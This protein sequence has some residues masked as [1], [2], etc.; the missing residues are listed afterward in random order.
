MASATIPV[1]LK[2]Q[3]TCGPHKGRQLDFY[4]EQ[5]Q[6][7]VCPKC[8]TSL[9]KGHLFCDLS[10]ITPKKE[11]KIR[12]FLDR[13][14]SSELVEIEH[15]IASANTLL[16]EN[17][18]TFEILAKQLTSQTERLKQDLEK[19]TAETLSFYQKTKEDNAKLIQKYKQDLGMCSKQLKQQMEECK[20]ALQQGSRIDIYD[21]ECEVDFWL[22]LPVKP[23]LRTACFIPN[24]NPRNHLELA[25]GTSVD[26]GQ[27]STLRFE[28]RSVSSSHGQGQSYTHQRPD[29]TK[30][31]VVISAKP[32]TMTKVLE[33]WKSPFDIDFICPIT[34]DQAWIGY[35]DTLT[36]LDRKGKVIQE[37]THKAYINDIS[38]SPTTH[39]LWVCDR[40]NSILELVSGQLSV[41]F[42]TKYQ[43]R[44]S[45][46]TAD[47][48]IIIGMHK[49][50]AKYTTQGQIVLT[51]E[52][53]GTATPLVCS[54][55]RIT[56]CPI[57]NNVAVIDD[58]NKSD[59]GDGA[60][61]VV[62]MDTELRELFMY[63]DDILNRYKETPQTRGYLFDICAIV[64]DSQ[65]NIILGDWVNDKI[66]ILNGDGAVLRI[67]PT[68]G[69]WA[70]GVSSQ[71]DLWNV[72]IYNN[73]TLLQYYE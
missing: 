26:S 47:N 42:R 48:H 30:K 56:E 20:T 43:P 67:I 69:V 59:G 38:L 39:R 2:R 36:L 66:H 53:T 16:K 23:M 15:Y 41:R 54:P 37:V 27:M 4:C 65:G 62:V 3:T 73:V 46:V 19:V 57:T 17:D 13:T 52:V 29:E 9:H 12:Q 49:H 18:S 32:L 33:M 28:D 64:Y 44:C 34:D 11:E 61:H 40:G 45:C 21:T 35:K 25:L 71:S 10:E 68:T 5:C 55:W 51:T 50:V 31:K 72:D 8:V 6:E 70:V 1:R 63:R 22:H 24:R 58:S 14:A 7:P 60:Q